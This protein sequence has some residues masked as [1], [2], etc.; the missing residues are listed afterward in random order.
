MALFAHA[1]LIGMVH[2]LPL[3]GSPGSRDSVRAIADRAAEEAK[4]LA[5]EGFAGI[6]VENMHD[7]PYVNAPHAPETVAAFAV[8]A[9]AVRAA[10]PG[11]RLGVQVLSF[12]HREALAVA[13]ACEA[14]FIRVENFVYSHVADEGLLPDA[15]A[16]GLL[17]VRRALGAERVQVYCDLKKK[18]AS[19]ALT[20]DLSIGD[21]A[22]GAEFF[23]ADGLIVTGAFT[24]TPADPGDLESVRGASPLPLLVGSGVTP[25]QLPSLLS[26]ADGLI[27]G[28]F[29]K[30]DGVWSNPVDPARCRE[31]V[32]ARRLALQ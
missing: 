12:G 5:S 10:A 23:G 7:R 19:H 22:K 13:I 20:Q 29:I 8:C 32:Q 2:L 31:L 3:P 25:E 15:A 1:D 4:V 17:R 6:I 26:L 16:G 27:V 9:A 30:R 11:V 18:H 28:S 24:G 21:T 14:Q